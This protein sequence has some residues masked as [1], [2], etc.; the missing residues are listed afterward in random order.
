PEGTL[1][2]GAG[3]K[4]GGFAATG[5]AIAGALE[6][7]GG[8]LRIH[9][10]NSKGSCD[11]VRRL[12][13]GEVDVALVQYDVAAE[14]FAAAAAGAEDVGELD[15][16]LESGWMC[17]LSAA[18]LAGVELQLV[19]AIND[20]AVHVI[21][22][23]PVRLEDFG[24][25]GERPIFAGQRGSGSMET[26]KVILG[27]AGLTLDDVNSLDIKTKA[28]QAAMQKGEL[29]LM[30]STTEVGDPAIGKLLASGM[31]GLNALPS[32]VIERL[33]DGFPYYR[34]CQIDAQSYPGLEFGVPTVCVSTVVLTARRRGEPLMTDDQVIELIDGL[35]FL[36]ENPVEDLPPISVRW[37]NFAEREPIPL[38]P[39]AGYIER[40][41]FVF[42]WAKVFA[43]L[44]LALAGLSVLRRYLRR[45]GLLG[46]PLTGNLE[47]QLSNPLV[48][49][50]GFLLI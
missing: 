28:A 33:I 26:S 40:R 32:S 10:E 31:A 8:E 7:T 2:F 38:H 1:R 3:S 4:G 35:R 42:Y 9:V 27:A 44:A 14:A 29:L 20:S 43:A 49:F 5:E 30:L 16:E 21:V 23:R 18:E 36:A 15:G 24:S 47:G 25:I 22:R 6:Q 12:A 19:A 17:E 39:G 11:N 45:K 41:D 48:P 50:A 37:R 34:V 13:R 46:N